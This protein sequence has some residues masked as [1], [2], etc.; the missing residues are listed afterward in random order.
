MQT[1]SVITCTYNPNPKIFERVL[2]SIECQSIAN[3][4]IEYVIVDNNSNPPVSEIPC[5]QAFLARNAWAKVITERRQ[6]LSYARI[7]GVKEASSD[8]IIFVDDDNELAS[9]YISEVVKLFNQYYFVGVWGAGDITVEFPEGVPLWVE[10]D[11]K[12]FFLEYTTVVDMYSHVV[13]NPEFKTTDRKAD[14]G[15]SWGDTQINWLAIKNGFAVGVSPDLKYNHLIPQKR[16]SIDYICNQTF[17]GIATGLTAFYEIFPDLKQSYEGIK[18]S[19][20]STFLLRF[21]KLL[22]TMNFNSLKIHIAGYFG[23]WES[24]YRGHRLTRPTS[25]RLFASLFLPIAKLRLPED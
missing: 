21:F 6:G 13:Q 17:D 10:K 4:D 7:A 19:K 8:I 12:A 16:T 18:P 20:R 14:S 5:V 15:A 1:I 24:Y 9:N 2:R 3:F 22:I 25:Y 23:G 11:M